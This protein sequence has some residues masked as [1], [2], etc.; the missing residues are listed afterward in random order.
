VGPHDAGH[1]AV[2]GVAPD[3]VVGRFFLFER[4]LQRFASDVQPDS[5]A[6]LEA[7]DDRLGGRVNPDGD[8]AFGMYLYTL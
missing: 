5:A 1:A 3:F 6:E 8:A 7:V 4:I 2:L